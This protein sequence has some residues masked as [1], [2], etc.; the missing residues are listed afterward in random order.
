MA[1]Q[2]EKPPLS[3]TPFHVLP[4]PY[5]GPIDGHSTSSPPN[6]STAGGGVRKQIEK[7]VKAVERRIDKQ[8]L[9]AQIRAYDLSPMPSTK[10]SNL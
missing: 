4:A 7:M 5:P 8:V 9:A 2:A 1:N 6:Q 10:S 3:E